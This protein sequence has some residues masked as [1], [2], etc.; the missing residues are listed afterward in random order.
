MHRLHRFPIFQFFLL[1]SRQAERGLL[2]A[3]ELAF[4]S[5]YWI[6]EVKV[7]DLTPPTIEDLS[8]L[9][10]GFSIHI[11]ITPNARLRLSILLIGF[12]RRITC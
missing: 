1:D 11:Q 5:S 8:I 3:E 4:N 9:L 7:A 10:I 6:R 2:E 12:K